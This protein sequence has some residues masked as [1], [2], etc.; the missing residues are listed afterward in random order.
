[1]TAEQGEVR[2]PGFVAPDEIRRFYSSASVTADRSFGDLHAT[3]G[4]TRLQEE[5][6]VLG[7]RFGFAPAGSGT[8]F[9]DASLRYDIS[10]KWGAEARYRGGWT[11]LPGGNGF[12]EGG[13]M[14]SDGWAL[15]L[16][17][18]SALRPG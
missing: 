11:Q 9:V 8:T 6:T 5:A 2:Q 10:R 3:L 12:V 7:A 4:I 17:R 14:A 15:D 13:N 1:V 18:R 16:W